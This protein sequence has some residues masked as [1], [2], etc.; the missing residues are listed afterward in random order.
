MVSNWWLG[1]ETSPEPIRKPPEK[2]EPH[3][4]ERWGERKKKND[5]IGASTAG[6]TD[7]KE[8]N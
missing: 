6:K 5:L 8:R 1:P 3:S 2:V 4:D 7:N